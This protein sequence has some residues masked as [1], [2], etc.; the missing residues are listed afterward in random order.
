MRIGKE[1]LL[2]RSIDLKITGVK[3]ANKKTDK[4]FAKAG[5]IFIEMTVE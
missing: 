2:S 1:C 5:N 4:R 3:I